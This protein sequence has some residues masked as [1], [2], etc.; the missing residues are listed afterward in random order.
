MAKRFTD[1]E[2]W[3]DAWFMD[4][5]AKYKLFW[6]YI[7]D[8]CN[9]AGVWKVNFKVASFYIGEHLEHSEVKRILNDRI[10]IID[11]KYWYIDKF[12]KYQYKCDVSGLNVKNNAHLS[13]INILN[14]YDLFKP[15]T[16]PLLGVMDKDKDKDKDKKKDLIIKAETDVLEIKEEER[17]KNTLYRDVD[18]LKDFNELRVFMK[19]SKVSNINSI[20]DYTAKAE[21]K[22]LSKIYKREDFVKAIKALF[23]QQQLPNGNTVMF[24]DPKHLILHFSRYLDAFENT[25]DALYGEKKKIQ[26]L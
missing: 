22:E 8:E 13:I 6:L 1:N 17:E 24:S 7:L 2:K 19:R 15:L 4:L 20:R 16:S 9:H 21:F 12:I 25:N 11:D 23:K 26:R 3:K 10:T 18:F 14:E 5:P